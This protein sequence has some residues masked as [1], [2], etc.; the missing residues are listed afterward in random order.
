MVN[1]AHA[2]AA[3]TQDVTETATA[4]ERPMEGTGGRSANCAWQVTITSTPQTL[5]VIRA[6]MCSCTILCWRQS[7]SSSLLHSS[8]QSSGCGDTHRGCRRIGCSARLL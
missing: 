1:G 4:T 6:G 7:C 2:E 8:G 3:L 5:G